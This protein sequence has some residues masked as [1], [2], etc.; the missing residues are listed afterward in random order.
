MAIQF[1]TVASC[2][3]IFFIFS[4]MKF[5]LAILELCLSGHLLRLHIRNECAVSVLQAY[6]NI[7]I[8]FF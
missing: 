5:L 6:I 7:L 8:T 2:L 4:K 3:F 1:K